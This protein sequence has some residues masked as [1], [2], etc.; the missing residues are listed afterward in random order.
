[1]LSADAKIILVITSV[2]YLSVYC[3][4]TL[5]NGTLLIYSLSTSAF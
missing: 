1:M 4:L 2:S 3:N 5:I